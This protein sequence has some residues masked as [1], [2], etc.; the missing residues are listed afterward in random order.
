[1]NDNNILI[2]LRGCAISSTS[3]FFVMKKERE[4]KG[5]HSKKVLVVC[6]VV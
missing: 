2:A 4:E 5:K 6:Y 1:M 3:R